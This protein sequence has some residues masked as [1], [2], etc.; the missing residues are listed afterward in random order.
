M[1]KNGIFVK[2]NPAALDDGLTLFFHN[3]FKY[4]RRS[5][6]SKSLVFLKH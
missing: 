4:E 2:S 3:K 5:I 1:R 6:S